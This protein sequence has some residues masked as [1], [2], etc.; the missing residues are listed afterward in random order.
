MSVAYYGEGEGTGWLVGPGSV[1]A[2]ELRKD[3][4]DVPFSDGGEA[5]GCSLRQA[6]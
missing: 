5:Y 3:R 6:R 4:R 1:E 2:G